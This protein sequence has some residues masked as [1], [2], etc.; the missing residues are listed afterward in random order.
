MKTPITNPVNDCQREFNR[1]CDLGG[2]MNG[3]P[4]RGRVRD[5]LRLH[6]QEL[7]DFAYGEMAKHLAACPDAN[8]WHVCFAFGLSWG[9]L[10]KLEVGFTVA[11]VGLLDRW[12]DADLA[13]ARKFPMERGADVTENCLRG[14]YLMFEKAKLE[15]TLPDSLKG[16]NRVQDRLLRAIQT[17]RPKYIGNWNAT[18]MFMTAL[19][20]Q[21]TLAST[22]K[23]QQPMLPPAGPIFK[24]L[25]LLHQAG[26]LSRAPDGS[27]L[28]DGPMEPGVVYVNNSLLEEIQAG[29]ADWSLIDVHSGVYMLGTRN[30]HSNG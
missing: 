8:P 25:Q 24:G 19:F 20:A 30:L 2:G 3:G 23:T 22:Y 6:G 15:P 27:E 26:L 29:H 11:A 7:N 18:A 17:E 28:A 12:N 4:A 13:Q 5:L 1:L 21:P 10:A 16:L 9:H 14:G